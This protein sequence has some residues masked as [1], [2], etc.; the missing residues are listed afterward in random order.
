M[1]WTL[2]AGFLGFAIAASFTPGPNNLIALSSGANFGFRKTL[3]HLMGVALGFGLMLFLVGL[4]LGALFEAV[5][6]VYNVLQVACLVYLLLLAWKMG[7]SGAI[8]SVKDREKPNSLFASALFQWVNP[9]AWFAS[10]TI[11]STFTDPQ[12]YWQS[13]S[14]NSVSIMIIAAAS[15][16]SWTLFGSVFQRLLSSPRR[17]SAFNWTMAAALVFSTVPAIF[18]FS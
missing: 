6:L 12:N 15:I 17:L 18:H 10:L 13:M 1:N 4:G 16:C 3:P 7:T 8:G 5:P 11:V 9:K 14:M 2:Y